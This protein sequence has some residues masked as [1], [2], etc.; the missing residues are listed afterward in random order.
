MRQY[1]SP[2]RVAG[3]VSSSWTTL[4]KGWDG[5][6]LTAAGHSLGTAELKAEATVSLPCD[7]RIQTP[8]ET[9]KSEVTEARVE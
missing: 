7:S 3:E 2:G 5:E 1:F 6:G 4:R 8:T 9:E